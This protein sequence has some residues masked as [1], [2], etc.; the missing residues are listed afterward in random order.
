MIDQI[1]NKLNE[2]VIKIDRKSF[3]VFWY[4]RMNNLFNKIV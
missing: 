2:V 1:I 3:N 4:E